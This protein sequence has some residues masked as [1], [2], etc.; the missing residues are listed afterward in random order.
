MEESQ[1]H[2]G[3]TYIFTNLRSSHA[4][5]PIVDYGHRC[6]I[7]SLAQKYM[8]SRGSKLDKIN[9][10]HSFLTQ[11]KLNK[12]QYF[13]EIIDFFV[14]YERYFLLLHRGELLCTFIT[15]P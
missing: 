9:F 14:V 15:T 3:C 12:I 1:W 5:K 4:V 7:L 11:M 8:Y 2:S 10:R 6:A 13:V